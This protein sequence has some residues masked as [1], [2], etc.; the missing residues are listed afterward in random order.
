MKTTRL[1]LTAALGLGA[2][3]ALHAFDLAKGLPK[4]EI[5]YF[6]PEKFTDVANRAFGDSDQER[7]ET[8]SDL[9]THFIKQANRLLAPGQQLKITFTDIDLAGEFEPWR[10]GALAD[11]RIVKDIYPPTMKLAF[12]LKDADGNVLKQGDRTLRDMGFM[13]TLSI[14]RNDPLRFEKELFDNWVRDEFR[15]LKNK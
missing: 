5:V 14:D 4:T 11:V 6:E 7:N 12:Q 3:S 13:M 1:L 2:V 10:G 8:L 15:G 9:R